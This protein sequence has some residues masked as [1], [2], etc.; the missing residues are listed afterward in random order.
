MEQVA[1]ALPTRGLVL[2]P[3]MLRVFPIGRPS[4]IRAIEMH[5]N[6]GSPLF[7]V[8]QR[9]AD[10]DDPL[11]ADLATVG[12]I[13]QALRVTSLPDGSMRVLLEG[14][15]RARRLSPISLENG[16]TSCQFEQI[17]TS[18]DDPVALGALSRQVAK[19]FQEFMLN[20]GVGNHE[21]S[22]L[23]ATHDDPGRLSDQIVGLVDLS[24]TERIALLEE[25]RVQ[26]RLES[27]MGHLAI[28]MAQQQLAIEVN[29]KVQAAMDK[30]QRDYHLKEQLKA[31][32]AELGEIVGVEAEAEAFAKKIKELGM[33][34]EA[35]REAMREVERLRSLHMESAEYT[36]SRTWLQT[37]CDI[38]W[39]KLTSDATDLRRA[40]TILDEDHYGLRKVKERI[41]EYL[42]VRQLQPLSKGAILCFVGPPGVGKTSL[43]QSIARALDRKY[44]RVAL[45]GIKDESE[46]RGH[47]R[48]YVGALP[49]R[50]IRAL[51]RAGTSNPVM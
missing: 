17:L 1:V 34:E 38:P 41:L 39:S 46:I 7:V 11:R 13:S 8:P 44:A 45:G 4:S 27:L 31:I 20:T 50:I 32:R 42:A 49:G 37:I 22:I 9:D 24:L 26:P 48:T 15:D 5:L 47:R 36:V 19:M 35:E 29:S 2:F 40:E 18:D 28:V 51:V 33:P 23:A 25:C 30:S 3:G 43:G 16:A 21:H 10:F 14:L 12:V 6:D